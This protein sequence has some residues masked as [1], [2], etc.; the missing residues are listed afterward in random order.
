MVRAELVD[1]PT[2]W[3]TRLHRPVRRIQ[4]LA[5]IVLTASVLLL[6][7]GVSWIVVGISNGDLRPALWQQA[8]IVIGLCTLV[9]LAGIAFRIAFFARLVRGFL[10]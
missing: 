1:S 7:L 5:I 10:R 9:A 3:R 4:N 2:P 6:V 8:L